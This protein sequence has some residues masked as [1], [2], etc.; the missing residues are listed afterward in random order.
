MWSRPRHLDSL[1]LFPRRLPGQGR[2]L[3]P[4]CLGSLPS[5]LVNWPA[6]AGAAF[7]GAVV[8]PVT[9][10]GN[11]RAG[12][13]RKTPCCGVLVPP[14]GPC[15]LGVSRQ[16]TH[17]VTGS[18]KQ[19]APLRVL[20]KD[21]KATGTWGAALAKPAAWRASCILG[22]HHPGQAPPRAHSGPWPRPQSILHQKAAAE[23]VALKGKPGQMRSLCGSGSSQE[24]EAVWE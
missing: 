8:G 17:Q 23:K 9:R 1:K 4:R 6:K 7:L 21:S 3:P 11:S 5:T 2:D 15:H 12:Q 13:S 24:T 16:R 22:P 20:G 14:K 10:P 19:A 18:V